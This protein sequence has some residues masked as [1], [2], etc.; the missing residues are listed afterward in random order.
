MGYR[1]ALFIRQSFV[2]MVISGNRHWCGNCSND[3]FSATEHGISSQCSR[4]FSRR[5][6]WI[7]DQAHLREEK[8]P[9][10]RKMAHS[11]YRLCA[12]VSHS[13]VNGGLYDS[14]SGMKRASES[15]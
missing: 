12:N 7:P 11:R 15:A 9:K 14:R 4:H 2:S 6:L 13:T 8:S 5:G 3:S 10:V 1:L